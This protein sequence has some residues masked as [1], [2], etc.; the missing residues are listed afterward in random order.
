[1]QG[2]LELAVDVGLDASAV[3]LRV[4]LKVRGREE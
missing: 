1:M 2:Q 3:K 4:S